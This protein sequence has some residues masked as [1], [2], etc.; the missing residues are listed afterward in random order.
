[1]LIENIVDHISCDESAIYGVPV[2][3]NLGFAETFAGAFA[4]SRRDDTSRFAE[5]RIPLARTKGH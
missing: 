3:R 2:I 5:K 1:M 4:K